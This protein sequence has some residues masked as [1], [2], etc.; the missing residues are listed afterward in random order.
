MLY[1]TDRTRGYKDPESPEYA[2]GIDRAE[3]LI[4]AF[5]DMQRRK[6]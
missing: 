4:Q 5:E 2:Y 1:V 3:K 6:P